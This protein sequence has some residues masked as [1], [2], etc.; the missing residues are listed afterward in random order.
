MDDYPRGPPH[1]GELHL[2]LMSWMGYFTRTMREIAGFVREVED[3]VSFGEIEK[4]ILDNLEGKIDCFFRS[5]VIYICH[6]DLHWSEEQ[7]MYC[8]VNVNSE[9]E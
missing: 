6:E 3:E 5:L 9:G 2:D 8:D 1:A 4:A 7:Q